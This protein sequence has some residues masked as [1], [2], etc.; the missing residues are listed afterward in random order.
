MLGLVPMCL[1]S[2]S[3]WYLPKTNIKYGEEANEKEYV[4]TPTYDGLKKH[5]ASGSDVEKVKDAN[6]QGGLALANG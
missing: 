1:S 4:A 6:E 5:V 3:R 2:R